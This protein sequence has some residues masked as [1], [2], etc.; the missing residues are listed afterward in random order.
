MTTKTPRSTYTP[1]SDG[2][3]VLRIFLWIFGGIIVIGMLCCICSLVFLWYTGD[4][5]VDFFRVLFQ[6]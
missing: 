5:I 3:K 6:Y 1:E 2:R 4:S